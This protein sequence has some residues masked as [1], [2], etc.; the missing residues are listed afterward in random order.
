MKSF[1]VILI[2]S[3]QL[4][5]N[6]KLRMKLDTTEELNQKTNIR[7]VHLPRW[8]YPLQNEDKIDRFQP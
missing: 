3:L 1:G 5:S 2:R 8:Q 6:L 7:V 4:K